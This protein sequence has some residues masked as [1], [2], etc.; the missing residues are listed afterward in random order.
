MLLAFI[1]GHVSKSKG[2]LHRGSTL[3][4]WAIKAMGTQSSHWKIMFT[5]VS[6]KCWNHYSVLAL[7]SLEDHLPF[8]EGNLFLHHHM[9]IF[10]KKVWWNWFAS[11]QHCG[12]SMEIDL[13]WGFVPLGFVQL[14]K[15]GFHCNII[16]E[17][18]M[19]F[20]LPL[21]VLGS[22]KSKEIF[23]FTLH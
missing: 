21:Y 12:K 3:Y 6:A 23:V 17:S 9:L 8:C 7:L 22:Y 16:L 20:L 10:S 14:C 19:F 2:C 5:N 1:S 13:S 18:E 11:H 4:H 15:F